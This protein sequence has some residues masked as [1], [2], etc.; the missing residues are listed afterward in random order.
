MIDISQ[1]GLNKGKKEFELEIIAKKLMIHA[2]LC[3]DL[4]LEYGKT[5][6]VIFSITISSIKAIPLSNF[7]QKNY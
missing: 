4:G 7:L 2:G 1:E 3:G 6:F 5:G